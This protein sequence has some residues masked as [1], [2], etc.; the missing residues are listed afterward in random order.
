MEE[1]DAD[2]TEMQED[3]ASHPMEK[4]V[5]ELPGVGTMTTIVGLADLIYKS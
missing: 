5:S 1:T 2:S 4:M 3:K